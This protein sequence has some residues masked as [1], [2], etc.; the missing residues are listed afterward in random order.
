VMDTAAQSSTAVSPPQDLR[1]KLKQIT[2]HKS[3]FP[4][5]C[6]ICPFMLYTITIPGEVTFGDSAEF[7]TAAYLL[8]GPHPSG[9]PLYILLGKLV[10]TIIP[11][12]TYG[13]RFTLLNCAFGGLACIWLYRTCRMLTNRR[14]FSFCA[15][16][17]YATCEIVWSECRHV[18]VYALHSFLMSACLFYLFRWHM[19]KQPRDVVIASAFFGFAFTNHLTTAFFFPAVVYIFFFVKP[20]VPL[21]WKLWVKISLVFVIPLS[22]YAYLPLQSMYGQGEKISWGGDLTNIK[23]L[24]FHVRGG[25]YGLYSAYK[26]LGDMATSIL[27]RFQ[28]FCRRLMEMFLVPGVALGL[29][30]IWEG[31]LEKRKI[32]LFFLIFAVTLLGYCLYYKIEDIDAYYLPVFQVFG[33]LMAFGLT[34]LN[35]SLGEIQFEKVTGYRIFYGAVAGIGAILIAA[36]SLVALSHSRSDPAVAG[37]GFLQYFHTGFKN[38]LPLVMF[39]GLLGAATIGVS[40]FFLAKKKA[41]VEPNLVAHARKVREFFRIIV[42]CI[43]LLPVILVYRNWFLKY[44]SL[45]APV[46]G[47]EIITKAEPGSIILTD[48]DGTTF[49]LWYY[50]Y[51]NKK[52]RRDDVTVIDIR[53]YH[54]ADWFREYLRKARPDIK[55]P[56][57]RKDPKYPQKKLGWW[58]YYHNVMHAPA[59]PMHYWDKPW[60]Q[61]GQDINVIPYILYKNLLTRENP[62]TIYTS[63][64]LQDYQREETNTWHYYMWGEFKTIN[65]GFLNRVVEKT[66]DE[67]T[68]KSS[69]NLAKHAAL[70]RELVKY[71]SFG[72]DRR[73]EPRGFADVFRPGESAFFLVVWSARY[74]RRVVHQWFGPD[75][76]RIHYEHGEDD[77]YTNQIWPSFDIPE[78]AEAGNYSMKLNSWR[79]IEVDLSELAGLETGDLDDETV[80]EIRVVPGS[81]LKVVKAKKPKVTGFRRPDRFIRPGDILLAIEVREDERSPFKEYNALVALLGERDERNRKNVGEH[82]KKTRCMSASGMRRFIR[83]AG[84]KFKPKRR[85][86]SIRTFKKSRAI[87]ARREPH[88]ERKFTVKP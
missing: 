85:D 59:G 34:R 49:V 51:V 64:G 86:I 44:D 38:V 56:D 26:S 81:C 62:P 76:T 84:G 32:L 63:F 35:T 25:Q 30:G 88:M 78:K 50:M 7:M 9:Y 65:N 36:A 73:I 29:F 16:M 10:M 69:I 83:F 70:I 31:W 4:A 79:L 33:V 27:E 6:F 60:P 39:L 52:T 75:G 72:Q 20:R 45:I 1:D 87:I 5:L 12:G 80:K 42:Y 15:V 19:K 82:D 41:S 77:K 3:F 57:Q 18:E 55:W 24:L 58:D 21:D 17:I 61:R 43:I 22:I 23:S 48:E 2:S 53:M 13:F 8:G 28:D 37:G 54:W 40:V 67:K 47:R 68:E 14:Y 66:E 71:R 46:Y 74:S 11:F